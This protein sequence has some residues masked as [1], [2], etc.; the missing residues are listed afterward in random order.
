MF[1]FLIEVEILANLDWAGFIGGFS[2]SGRPEYRQCAYLH[3]ALNMEVEGSL[4][5]IS[6]AVPVY[7]SPI[8]KLEKRLVWRNSQV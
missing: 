4:Q 2:R 7:P 8:A 6:A 3:E 1:G 5:I